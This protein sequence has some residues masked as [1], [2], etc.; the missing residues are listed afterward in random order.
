MKGK[1]MPNKKV[2]LPAPSTVIQIIHMESLIWF[3][4]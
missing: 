1:L 2:S 4:H 3:S